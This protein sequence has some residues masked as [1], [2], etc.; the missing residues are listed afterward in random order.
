MAATTTTTTTTGKGGWVPGLLRWWCL[1]IRFQQPPVVVSFSLHPFFFY[2][3]GSI[4]DIN[5]EAMLEAPFQEKSASDLL[6]EKKANV[7]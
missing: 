1:A 2:C 6:T 5:V 4:M 3:T 7:D